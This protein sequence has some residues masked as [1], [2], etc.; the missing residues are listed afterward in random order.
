VPVLR[1]DDFD[2]GVALSELH[3][4]TRRRWRA[5]LMHANGRQS[6]RKSV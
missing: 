6:A 5:A 2:Q 3:F 4:R 1:V